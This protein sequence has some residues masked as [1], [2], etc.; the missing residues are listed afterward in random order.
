MTCSTIRSKY[1]R[2]SMILRVGLVQGNTEEVMNDGSTPAATTELEHVFQK[3]DFARMHVIGQF[4]LGF[5]LARLRNDLFIIDQHASD[6][7]YNFERLYQ[8]TVLQRQPLV[9]PQ[10]L[11][12]APA[13]EAIVRWAGP[14][15]AVDELC[16]PVS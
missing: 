5:I 7:K 3:S 1:S 12:L 4:N 9:H 16:K 2:E 13:E 14:S 6:E 8:T 11:H 15:L 10:P